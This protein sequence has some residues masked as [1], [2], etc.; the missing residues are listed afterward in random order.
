MDDLLDLADTLDGDDD[1]AT[2]DLAPHRPG[3][4]LAVAHQGHG[5][6]HLDPLILDPGE[7][8]SIVLCMAQQ[9]PLLVAHAYRFEPFLLAA[10][11]P[12][13]LDLDGDGVPDHTRWGTPVERVDGYLRADGTEVAGHYRTVADGSRVNNLGQVR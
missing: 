13:L 8:H 5:S 10:G 11:D 1:G 12:I 2:F 9:D 4:A 6:T 3:S 7:P